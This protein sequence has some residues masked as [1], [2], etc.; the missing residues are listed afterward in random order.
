MI[1]N[2]CGV[3][4]FGLGILLQNGQIKKM[5]SSYVGEN[6]LF[7]QQYIN[8]TLELELNP[9][10][11]LAERIRAGGSGIA[12][13]YT[14]TGVGT[15]A[16]DGKETKLFDGELYVME[17]ALHAD[18]AIIKGWKA[19]EAGNVVY[20]KTAQN[21]NPIMATAAKLTVCE[22]E[23]I[24]NTGTFDANHIHTPGIYVHRL[25]K[26]EKYEKRIEKLT[27]RDR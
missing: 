21:F 12:A 24:V 23:E 27:T 7:E 6:K 11:T 8:G 13:F 3:D 1:S 19:D 15:V 9:Q 2:N 10:G 20:D 22:V 25:V 16:A 5:I 4:D 17:K 18:L 14:K 26:G